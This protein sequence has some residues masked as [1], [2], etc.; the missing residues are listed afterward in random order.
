MS[1]HSTLK[2]NQASMIPIVTPD[3]VSS[4]SKYWHLNDTTKSRFQSTEYLNYDTTIKF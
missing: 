2:E 3:T 1:Q 4:S